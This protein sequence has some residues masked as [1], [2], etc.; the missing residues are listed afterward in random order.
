MLIVTVVIVRGTRENANYDHCEDQDALNDH[1]DGNKDDFAI[2]FID[3]WQEVV[4]DLGELIAAIIDKRKRVDGFISLHELLLLAK[5]EEDGDNE[6]NHLDAQAATNWCLH[7]RLSELLFLA[8]S[9]NKTEC[10]GECH[11]KGDAVGDGLQDDDDCLVKGLLVLFEVCG[12]NDTIARVLQFTLDRPRNG[13]SN[14]EAIFD[15]L[16]VLIGHIGRVI[17]KVFKC[18]EHSALLLDVIFCDFKTQ[19]NI[20]GIVAL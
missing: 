6:D 4:W 18:I 19:V 9:A 12:F 15:I 11:D 10:E 13:R 14:P 20:P 17:G 7:L 5:N 2:C 8:T 1:S 3:L 16:L